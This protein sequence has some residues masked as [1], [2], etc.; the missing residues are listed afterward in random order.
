MKIKIIFSEEECARKVYM[1][2][3]NQPQNKFEMQTFSV[4]FFLQVA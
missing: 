2:L 1:N 4:S 3:T